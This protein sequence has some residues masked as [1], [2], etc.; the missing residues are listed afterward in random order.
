MEYKSKHTGEQIDSGIDKALGM[1]NS[2][3]NAVDAEATARTQAITTA[4][5]GEE[6]NRNAA[7]KSEI[8]KEVTN[9]DSAIQSAIDTEVTNRNA[10]I[11]EAIDGLDLS[12]G[13]SS[14]GG[15]SGGGTSSGGESYITLTA[16]ESSPV[17]L[18]AITTAGTYRI[19]GDIDFVDNMPA[20][21]VP[22]GFKAENGVVLRVAEGVNSQGTTICTQEL[23]IPTC[24][25][26]FLRVKRTSFM[27]WT[28]PVIAQSKTNFATEDEG[29]YLN[30]TQGSTNTKDGVTVNAGDKFDQINR[31]AGT[32]VHQVLFHYPASGE[33]NIYIRSNVGSNTKYRKV[34]TQ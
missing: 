13:G 12:G 19:M 17:D 34:L 4:I 28:S 15:T 14:G 23:I 3:K 8:A 30:C 24:E 10:A 21:N 9:R 26:Y 20:Y 5:K 29:F 27:K 1:D 31:L 11:K 32:A 2:I 6:A 33:M 25:S 7:I 22:E 18:D 16:T